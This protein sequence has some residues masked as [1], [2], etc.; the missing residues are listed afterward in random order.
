M[1]HTFG[2]NMRHTEPGGP[3][4][5][6]SHLASLRHVRVLSHV[7]VHF[8]QRTPREQID[9]L[10]YRLGCEAQSASS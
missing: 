2:S 5:R 3:R 6:W 7:E 4:V 1:R 10:G 9:L 8:Q